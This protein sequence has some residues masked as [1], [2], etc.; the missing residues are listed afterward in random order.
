[1]LLFTFLRV[2]A[3]IALPGLVVLLA[4]CSVC[5]PVQPITSNIQAAGQ[6]EITAGLQVSG[7]LEAGAVYSPAPRMLVAGGGSYK[8]RLGSTPDYFLQTRQ[9]ELGAGSYFPLGQRGLLTGLLGYGQ[10]SS[11][12]ST[13]YGSGGGLTGNSIFACDTRYHKAF[14]QL[15]LSIIN[16]RNSYNWTVRYAYLNF[17]YL[18]VLDYSTG[19]V[20]PVEM[21]HLQQLAFVFCFRSYLGAPPGNWQFQATA[22]VAGTLRPV[23]F[24]S[25]EDRYNGGS[26][27][28]K[29]L[30]L[31]SAGVVFTSGA[32]RKTK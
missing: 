6:A 5:A 20:I 32:H 25:Y 8:P 31:A 18:N 4:S 3:A 16:P 30:L 21:Q 7:R 29:P 27:T 1:M 22:G 12:R 11:T 28:Q 26:E 24:D 17:D 9:W 19:E 15:G 2:P 14:G 13:G 23:E 10:A